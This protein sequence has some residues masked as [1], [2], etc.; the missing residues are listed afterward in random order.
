MPINCRCDC[1]DCDAA[2]HANNHCHR[3]PCRYANISVQRQ[4]RQA[5]DPAH[6]TANWHNSVKGCVECEWERLERW[7]QAN[8]IIASSH[9]PKHFVDQMIAYLKVSE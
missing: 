3:W 5:I 9:G 2:K 1:D 4:T 7:C 8:G 6:A